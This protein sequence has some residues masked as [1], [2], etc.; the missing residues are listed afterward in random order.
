[1]GA[2]RSE[3]RRKAMGEV[4]RMATKA[5]RARTQAKA[6]PPKA[7]EPEPKAKDEDEL[8][9]EDARALIAAYESH[10]DTPEA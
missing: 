4:L 10:G 8:S 9:D 1:M 7:P 5:M 3:A 6:G 2:S